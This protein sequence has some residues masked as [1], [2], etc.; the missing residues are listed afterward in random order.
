MIKKYT[1]YD[2]MLPCLLYATVSEVRLDEK[3]AVS[4]VDI[5]GSNWNNE[6]EIPITQS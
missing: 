1:Y 4:T 5:N 6:T 2:S 3:G